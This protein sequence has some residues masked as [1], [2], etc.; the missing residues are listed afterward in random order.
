MLMDYLYEQELQVELLDS[1]L[2]NADTCRFAIQIPVEKEDD[3]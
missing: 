3:R 1:A 2:D